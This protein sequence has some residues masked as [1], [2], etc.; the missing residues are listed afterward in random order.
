M[1]LQLSRKVFESIVAA[2]MQEISNNRRKPQ[3]HW[4]KT[5]KKISS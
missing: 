4:A 5:V 2:E 1:Y 3:Q